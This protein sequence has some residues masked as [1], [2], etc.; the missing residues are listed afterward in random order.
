VTGGRIGWLSSLVVG[1][2]VGVESSPTAPEQPAPR[3]VTP[4]GQA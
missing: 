2:V 4:L 1:F 3:A